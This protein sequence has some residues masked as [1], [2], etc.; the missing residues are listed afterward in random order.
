VKR[1]DWWRAFETFRGPSFCDYGWEWTSHFLW[2]GCCVQGGSGAMDDG[3]A[4]V[5]LVME[6]AAIKSSATT[7]RAS[8]L[9]RHCHTKR[10]QRSWCKLGGRFH[11][12]AKHVRNNSP[13]S[14]HG[15]CEGGHRC[16]NWSKNECRSIT[17][18]DQIPEGGVRVTLLRSLRLSLFALALWWC[19]VCAL[20]S[21]WRVLAV[22]ASMRIIISV[23]WVRNASNIHC[24]GDR[25]TLSSRHVKERHRDCCTV[26]A[27]WRHLDSL[28]VT[29]PLRLFQR[30]YRISVLPENRF[31]HS[32]LF[33]YSPYSRTSCM[34]C[35]SKNGYSHWEIDFP[36]TKML[37]PGFERRFAT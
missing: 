28:S 25:T 26:L 20:L 8:S 6:K 24:G 19:H 9:A 35:R 31:P 16:E 33:R 5:A 2:R 17:C 7:C 11:S 15:H 27:S 21:S 4:L 37:L 14:K 30:K 22:I 32:L 3:A 12:R 29:I 13:S 36:P 10:Q 34:P 18:R 1:S 23:S